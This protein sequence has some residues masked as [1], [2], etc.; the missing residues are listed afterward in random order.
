MQ[1]LTY[2][3]TSLLGSSF[4]QKISSDQHLNWEL[5]RVCSSP[6]HSFFTYLKNSFHEYL[7]LGFPLPMGK[8]EFDYSLEYDFWD[9]KSS[10]ESI[11][12]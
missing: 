9:A 3:T 2:L 6:S 4:L 5:A 7:D 11:H 1:I 10:S 12:L 8:A